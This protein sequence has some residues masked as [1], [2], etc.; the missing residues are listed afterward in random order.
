LH[1]EQNENEDKDRK[2]NQNQLT[3]AQNKQVTWQGAET[4]GSEGD[5]V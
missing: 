4:E 1:D 5:K 2:A 3:E